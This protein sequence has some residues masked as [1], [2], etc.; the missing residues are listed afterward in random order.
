MGLLSSRL[1]QAG[2]ATVFISSRKRAACEAACAALNALPGLASG[3]RAVPAP[4]DSASLDGIK[5]LVAQV[6]EHTDGVDI[7]LANAGATWGESFD[8]HPDSA[9]AKVLDLNVRAGM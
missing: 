3:A 5:E 9:I 8:T 7:L 2:A 4:A 1:L 6:S